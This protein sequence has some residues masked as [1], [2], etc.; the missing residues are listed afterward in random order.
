MANVPYLGVRAAVDLVVPTGIDAGEIYKF[1]V[2]RKKMTAADLMRR[3]AAAVGGANEELIRTYGSVLNFTEGL[4]TTERQGEGSRTMTPT[5]AEFTEADAVRSENVGHMLRREKYEDA[6]G[7]SQDWLEE[8]AT[9]DDVQNDLQLIIDRWINR[10]DYNFWTRVLTDDEN[11]VG[12]AGYDTGWAIGTGTN[13]DYIPPQYLSNVFDSTHTHYLSED[14]WD[15]LLEAMVATLREHGIGGRLL[16]I[17]SESDLATVTALSN[18]AKIKP[19]EIM[20]TPGGNAS[21]PIAYTTGRPFEGVPGE[22]IGLYNSTRGLVEVRY[23]PRVPQYYAWMTKPYGMGSPQNGPVIR[24]FPGKPWGLTPA[25]E[26][27]KHVNPRLEKVS[28]EAD[29][30]VGVWN[31]LNGVAG[32]K[33]SGETWVDASIT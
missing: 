30:G 9:E 16:C 6:L 22:M 12:T 3:M 2:L 10:V 7:W 13:V 8:A 29:F 28:F 31:R 20:Y 24:Q 11:A 5:K 26:L 15:D 21:Q 23:H 14:D 4:S 32:F 33:D 1:T 18:F 25:V 19:S 17:I 27:T